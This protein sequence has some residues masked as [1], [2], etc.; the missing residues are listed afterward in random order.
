MKN[1]FYCRVSGKK[2]KIPEDEKDYCYL[3]SYE[4]TFEQVKILDIILII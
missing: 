1:I 3:Q 2:C 4:T